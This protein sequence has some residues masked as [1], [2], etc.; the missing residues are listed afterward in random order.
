MKKE[1]KENLKKSI[2]EI[3]QQGSRAKDPLLEERNSLIRNII[4]FFVFLLLTSV[5]TYA[6]FWKYE[7]HKKAKENQTKASILSATSQA[8]EKQI[9]AQE[10]ENNS[11]KAEEEK[12][13][14]KKPEEL[15]VVAL[16]GG[17]MKGAAGKAQVILKEKGYS[18]A[19]ASNSAANYSGVTLFFAGDL[20]AEALELKE[21]IS[22]DFP[23]IV[24]KE[25]ASQE[26]KMADLVLILGK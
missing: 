8:E 22:D 24:T 10:E 15:K 6:G 16:N 26:E 3:Y 18:Q 25:A 1:K 14:L 9:L 12:V 11:S 23:Q 7:E 2:E 4:G 20:E 13:K 5:A 17:A 19:R 21:K